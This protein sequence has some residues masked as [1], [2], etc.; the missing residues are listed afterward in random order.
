MQT[1]LS[2]KQSSLNLEKKRLSDLAA[3]VDRD[4]ITLDRYNQYSVDA[5]NRKV[6]QVNSMNDQVQSSV[7]DFNR[8]VDAFNSELERV[9]TL[10]N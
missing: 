4:R 6:N 3:E 2:F 10:I 5:F 7:N 8:D 9:G 1:S